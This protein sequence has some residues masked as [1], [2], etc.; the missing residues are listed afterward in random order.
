MQRFFDILFSFVAI[1]FF[2]PL[3]IVVALLLLSTGENKVIYLQK[4]VGHG[5][6]LFS[7]IK[8]ATMLEDS[9]NSGTITFDRD[10]R[11]LPL[12]HLL[13]KSKINEL[14]QLFNIFFGDMSIIGPRPLT[15]ETFSYYSSDVGQLILKL[16]PGLSGVGSIF[17]RNEQ[18]LLNNGN[19]LNV[20][21]NKIAPYKGRLEVWYSENNTLVNYFKL[22]FATIITIFFPKIDILNFLFKDLPA[23]PSNVKFN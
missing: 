5:G 23:Q 19:Y 15:E 2:S 13:R 7:L 22:I 8:F 10:P 4:R 20:Y 9:A 18:L 1:I 17:F 16:K 11:I 6:K 14:P 21:K 12:G 3:L